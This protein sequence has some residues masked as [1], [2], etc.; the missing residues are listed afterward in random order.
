MLWVVL[1]CNWKI[2]VKMNNSR[3][4]CIAL[5]THKTLK[6]KNNLKGIGV[7]G[8]I[9]KIYNKVLS[10]NDSLEIYLQDRS[11]PYSTIYHESIAIFS[12]YRKR[13]S[14]VP[15]VAILSRWISHWSYLN[16]FDSCREQLNTIAWS[17]QFTYIPLCPNF[18]LNRMVY[19]VIFDHALERKLCMS[20]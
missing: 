10:I 7:L 5:I 11:Y 19:T 18:T 20:N 12:N 3:K 1:I 16:L 6:K 17:N 15:T 4:K 2:L 9:S 8:N 13:E 14:N